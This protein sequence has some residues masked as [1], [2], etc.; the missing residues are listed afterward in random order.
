MKRYWLTIAVVLLCAGLFAYLK[1]SGHKQ[2][3]DAAG[4]EQSFVSIMNIPQ[5]D[6]KRVEFEKFVRLMVNGKSEVSSASRTILDRAGNAWKVAEPGPPRVSSQQAVEQLLWLL[7]SFQAE[8]AVENDPKDLAKYG[9]D[10]PTES[11]SLTTKDNKVHT[12]LI[13]NTSP[14]GRYYVMV[15]GE[16]PVYVVPAEYAQPLLSPEVL[17]D[18]S[19][20]DA[21]PATKFTSVTVAEG[22]QTATCT[23]VNGKWQF[24]GALSGDCDAKQSALLRLVNSTQVMDYLAG[25]KLPKDLA[26]I[27]LRPPETVI[28]L[29]TDKKAS[30][31]LNVGKQAGGALFLENANR[32]EVYKVQFT[33]GESARGFLKPGNPTPEAET[34][35]VTPGEGEEPMMAPGE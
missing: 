2:K 35:P 31:T 24:T 17:V 28:T 16:K 27:G 26:E 33:F 32:K 23:L 15:K 8:R 29:S 3:P 21:D 5:E 12:L 10:K 13:G 6:V 11:V 18:R 14:T 34:Q 1:F 25:A 4:G 30:V 9:L 7:C 20:I 19:I 22:A